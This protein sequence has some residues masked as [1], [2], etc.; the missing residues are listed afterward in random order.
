MAAESGGELR[1]GRHPV[2]ERL[3]QQKLGELVEEAPPLRRLGEELARCSGTRLVDWMDY[4]VL[5]DGQAPRDSLEEAGFEYE[6]VPAGAGDLAFYHPG[7]VFPR[8]VLRAADGQPPGAVLAAALGVEEAARFLMAHRIAAPIEGA[9]LSAFRRARVWQE[10]RS[11]D[12]AP[13]R[14]LWVVERRGS[15]RLVPEAAGPSGG[16]EGGYLEAFERWASRERLFADPRE[17]MLRTLER[18]R[19][20]A[21]ELGPDRAAW[22]V[23]EAERAFWQARNRAGRVQKGRQDRLGMGWANHDHHT[24]RSSREVFSI[25]IRILETLG[26]RPRERFYAGRQAGW[27]AQIL[28]NQ[29]CGI[30]VFADVDLAPEEVGVDFAHQALEPRDI[31]G[32][33]GLWCALHG[34]S[35]LGAGMHHLAARLDFR[36]GRAGL[37]GEGVRMMPPFSNFA[38]LRQAFTRGETWEVEEARLAGLERSGR[39][40]PELL[41]RFRAEGAIGSHLESI[42]R[43]R[44]FKGFNQV[45]VSDIIRRTDPRGA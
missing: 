19:R 42:Q 43:A 35:L 31:L 8:I 22:I 29:A 16:A 36:G 27:G 32:T 44:G 26:F 7:A 12:S 28:E 23:F 9:P 41:A 21:G 33:V 38:H 13:P 24:F 39:V 14:E 3:I 45:S 4:L 6:D 11:S 15:R 2:G 10:P 17:G 18:A 5:A 1:W 40:R 37:A 30:A 20:L 25:L 34:E